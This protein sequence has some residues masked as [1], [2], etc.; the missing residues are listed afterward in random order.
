[1]WDSSWMTNSG[2]PENNFL[3]KIVCDFSEKEKKNKSSS[4]SRKYMSK[5][6]LLSDLTYQFPYREMR[7]LYTNDGTISLPFPRVD[8]LKVK[9]PEFLCLFSEY[10]QLFSLEIFGNFACFFVK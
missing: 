10:M 7:S 3:K 9:I 6:K 4:F 5:K 2:L 8:F 1:M